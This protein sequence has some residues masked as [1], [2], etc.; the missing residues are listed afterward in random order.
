M[1]RNGQLNLITGC[2]PVM[3]VHGMDGAFA[4]SLTVFS[5]VSN[6]HLHAMASQCIMVEVLG[7]RAAVKY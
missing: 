6:S 7:V 4:E 5:C 2:D 1:H 3:S